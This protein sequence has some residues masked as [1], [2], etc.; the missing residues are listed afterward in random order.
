MKKREILFSNQ[1][2]LLLNKLKEPVCAIDDFSELLVSDGCD[3]VARTFGSLL[4]QQEC[5]EVLKAIDD[6]LFQNVH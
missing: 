5:E 1:T 3:A 4:I 2:V 6:A